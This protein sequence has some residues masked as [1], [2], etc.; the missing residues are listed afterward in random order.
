MNNLIRILIIFLSMIGCAQSDDTTIDIDEIEKHI[1][2]LVPDDGKVNGMAHRYL[3]KT[4][5]PAGKLIIKHIFNKPEI[6]FKG[7]DRNLGK[8]LYG[9]QS[10]AATVLGQMRYLKALPILKEHFNRNVPRYLKASLMESIKILETTNS[11]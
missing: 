11:K 1:R 8:W 6:F 2:W 10:N 7:Y 5:V 4:G 9:T 3:V